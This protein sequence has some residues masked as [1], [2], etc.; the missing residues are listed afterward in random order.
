MAVAEK[1]KQ[2]SRKISLK[3]LRGVKGAGGGRMD[4]IPMPA[5]WRGTSV[6]VCGLNPFSTGN[7]VPMVGVPLGKRMSDGQ[8]QTVCFDPIAWFERAGILNN[9]SM[10]V[11]GIP[12]IGKSSLIRHIATGLAGYGTHTMVLNDQKPD[13]ADLVDALGGQVISLAP[14]VAGLNPLD[15]GIISEAAERL[16]AAGRTD[17]ASQM[18]ESGHAQRKNMLELLVRLALRRDLLPREENT[19]NAAIMWWEQ[20][21]TDV[22]A[23]PL[24]RDILAILREAPPLLH[25]AALTHGDTKMYR[26][27]LIDVESALMTLDGSMF[28]GIFS[29]PT[30]HPMRLD[31][32]VAFDISGLPKKQ[33]NLLAAVTLACWTY[34]FGNIEAQQVLADAGLEPRGRFFVVLDEMWQTLRAGLGVVDYVDSLTRLNRTQGVALA[35]CTHTPSDYDAIADAEDRAKALGLA[36]RS[37]CLVLGGLST[38]DVEKLEKTQVKFSQKEKDLL[39][40][41]SGP[42][43]V[44]VDGKKGTPPGRGRFLIKIGMEPGIDVEVVLT[45]VE[46]AVNDTNK[47]WANSTTTTAKQTSQETPTADTGEVSRPFVVIDEEEILGQHRSNTSGT[48]VQLR[49]AEKEARWSS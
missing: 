34:G 38:K 8:M 15:T 45:D 31:R 18:R 32:S 2:D 13:Y 28:G 33:G 7:P 35:M 39:A 21:N 3:A 14:G 23:Q 16:E 30:S 49:R 43:P 19:L 22:K 46:I 24:L 42:A 37:G 9:P 36:D 4:A 47:R 26:Q 6:Q 44:N 11:F 25:E 48:R 27:M 41:W 5:L 1:K 10:S 29:Q 40:R 20:N 12:G 17:L